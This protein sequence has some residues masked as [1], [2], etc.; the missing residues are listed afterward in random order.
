MGGRDAF[1]RDQAR[2]L[3]LTITAQ[4]EE[5]LDSCTE[6][7]AVSA[8][9]STSSSHPVRAFHSEHLR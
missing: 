6:R 8:R 3:K 5:N 2:P 1:P 9:W 4:P 7:S